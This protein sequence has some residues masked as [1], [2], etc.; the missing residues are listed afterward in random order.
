MVAFIDEYR[1]AYGVEPIC[2]VLPIAPST[3]Y[4]QKARQADP[5]RLPRRRISRTRNEC[6][7][8]STELARSWKSSKALLTDALPLTSGCSLP[9]N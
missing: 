1:D 4:K 7:T 3:Y 6:E 8:S 9:W 2:Q 5:S